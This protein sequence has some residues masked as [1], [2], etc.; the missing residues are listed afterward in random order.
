MLSK[1]QLLS[2]KPAVVPVEVTVPSWPDS[3]LLRHPTF[4]EWH[5]IMSSMRDR[6]EKGPTDEMIVNTIGVCLSTP[7]GGRLLTPAEA[8]Q[9]LRQEPGAIMELYGQCWKTVLKMDNALADA[10]KK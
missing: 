4:Q 1:D 9:L 10:E 3:V 7:E 6:G 8:T 2:I 5:G